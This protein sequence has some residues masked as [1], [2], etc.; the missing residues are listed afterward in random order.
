MDY[1]RNLRATSLGSARFRHSGG[2]MYQRNAEAVQNV[3][4]MQN[5]Q[6]VQNVQNMQNVQDRCD[7]TKTASDHTA[8]NVYPSLA[9]VYSPYQ[10]FTDIYPYECALD[11]GTLFRELNLP[12]EEKR[13]CSR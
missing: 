6:N 8:S 7:N 5:V 10:T 13:S 2:N 9:M 11:Q 1:Q 4:N 12:L 3:Q